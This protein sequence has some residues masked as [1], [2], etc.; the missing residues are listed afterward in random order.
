MS[1]K[2]GIAS[3][4]SNWGLHCGLDHSA[5]IKPLAHLW[6]LVSRWPLSACCP[7]AWG[8]GCW[9]RGNTGRSP[10]HSQ[11]TW[12]LNKLPSGTP[13]LKDVN[14][15]ELDSFLL[16]GGARRKKGM[17]TVHKAMP[18]ANLSK[19]TILPILLQNQ[20]YRW[21]IIVLTVDFPLSPK[22]TLSKH[23]RIRCS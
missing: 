10:P 15:D 22:L 17:P 9:S 8:Y 14:S 23:S 16:N 4:I 1:W 20:N 13:G 6:P 5:Q 12:C 21:K 3:A 2:I 18:T 19:L 7:A 11:M